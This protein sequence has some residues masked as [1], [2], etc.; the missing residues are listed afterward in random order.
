MI[1]VY[2]PITNKEK[3]FGLWFYCYKSMAIY[4]LF[5][6][7]IIIIIIIII[8]LNILFYYFLIKILWTL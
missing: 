3:K 8:I 4:Y 7:N 2:Y 1:N 5:I 6:I